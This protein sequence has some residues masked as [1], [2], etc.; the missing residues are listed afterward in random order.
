MTT[1][2]LQISYLFKKSRGKAD[3]DAQREFYE[4]II[5]SNTILSPEDIWFDASFLPTTAPAQLGNEEDYVAILPNQT[6]LPVLRRYIDH[7]LPQVAGSPA[8]FYSPELQF[9]LPHDYRDGSFHYTLKD[10]SGSEIAYGLHNWIVDQGSGVLTFFG[11]IPDGIQLPLQISFY[12]Y[13]GRF[14]LTGFVRTDGTLPMEDGYV[15]TIPQDVMTKLY[16]DQGLSALD[17]M[18]EKLKPKAPAN[19]STVLPVPAESYQAFE[20]STG[21]QHL[22]VAEAIPLLTLNQPFMD[23]DSGVLAAFEDDVQI[24]T[25]TLTTANDTGAYGAVIILA[26][27]DPYAGVES[28]SG[29]YKQLRAAIKPNLALSLGHHQM[30]A[31]YT[32]DPAKPATYFPNAQ[33][34]G[35][36]NTSLKADFYK[37]DPATTSVTDDVFTLPQNLT[38]F[39]S[40]VPTLDSTSYLNVDFVIK[41]AVK[42]H[43]GALGAKITSSQLLNV[44]EAITFTPNNGDDLPF[45][46]GLSV[47]PNVYT[48]QLQFQIVGLNSKQDFGTP[49]MITSPSRIDTV[50][51]E[52][53]RLDSGAGLFPAVFGVAYD[54]RISLLDNEELQ[55]I[56]GVYRWPAGDYSGNIPTAGP[57]YSLIPQTGIR[58]VTFQ[59]F[60]LLNNNGFTLTFN[61]AQN[62]IANT[63]NN[64]TA[65]LKVF[66][67]VDSTGWIDCN[68]PYPGVGV[69]LQDGDPAM[70]V[71]G[72]SATS[73]KVTFGPTVRSGPLYIRIGL[74]AGNMA[75]GTISALG[76]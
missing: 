76:N 75:F 22:C 5:K 74:S 16:A 26:D 59:P 58:W 47:R 72:S 51:N 65:G 19:I 21:V 2:E 1:D 12:K 32:T 14:G 27:E 67:K 73:K 11:G 23:G 15:P 25:H 7:P 66:A 44:D 42:S 38:K 24:G 8:S 68:S 37:D 4:E 46:Q 61:N 62:W 36:V 31:T 18:L 9:A 28:K 10:A 57:N 40:G 3:T 33:P 54:P 70:I 35:T 52:T 63:E 48:E 50:S 64:T 41:S 6:Q 53:G 20:A 43:Y 45:S 30:W 17:I 56:N 49:K 29:F 55:L 71:S 34:G 13:I 69:P 39:I 60:T